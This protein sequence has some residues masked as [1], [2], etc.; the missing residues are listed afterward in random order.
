[1]DVSVS[2]AGFC[3]ATG[4]CPSTSCSFS[5]STLFSSG[6]APLPLPSALGSSSKSSSSNSSSYP[7]LSSRVSTVSSSAFPA[8]FVEGGALPAASAATSRGVLASETA[9]SSGST[10]ALSGVFASGS[11]GLIFP[12]VGEKRPSPVNAKWTSAGSSTGVLAFLSMGRL[13][14]GSLI[15]SCCWPWGALLGTPCVLSR[16][17]PSSLKDLRCFLRRFLPPAFPFCLCFCLLWRFP[18]FVE[19]SSSASPPSTEAPI[20]PSSCSGSASAIALGSPS[21]DGASASP[22]CSLVDL[23]TTSRIT[24]LAACTLPN[25]P[26]V[27]LALISVSLSSSGFPRKKFPILCASLPSVAG[28]KSRSPYILSK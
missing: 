9:S 22:P 13:M 24:I 17:A 12:G 27:P 20:R 11:R 26:R 16:S 2:A 18:F 28:T 23:R 21:C 4:G 3:L 10:S 15:V 8:V 7:P 14:T 5:S 25:A 1:M 6:A 19:S